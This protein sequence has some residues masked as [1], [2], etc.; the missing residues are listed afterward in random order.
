VDATSRVAR[1]SR[2]G[3]VIVAVWVVVTTTTQIDR[4]ATLTGDAVV[5]VAGVAVVTICVSLA[6]TRQRRVLACVV[7]AGVL[8]AEICVSAL[9]VAGTAALD[10]VEI[11]DAA[12]RALK[13]QVTG[14]DGGDISGG[15]WSSDRAVCVT[16]A[17]LSVHIEAAAHQGSRRLSNRESEGTHLDIARVANGQLPPG[18]NRRTCRILDLLVCIVPRA[19]G[20]IIRDYT[21]G[22]VA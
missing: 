18:R 17:T 21:R 22:G 19:V 1:V 16:Q 10:C 3:D 11:T 13:A 8:G 6:A 2:A 5:L 14:V 9:A 12:D 7:L 4:V 15:F 20:L